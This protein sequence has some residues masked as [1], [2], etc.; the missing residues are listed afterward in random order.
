MLTLTRI[1]NLGIRIQGHNQTNAVVTEKRGGG[2]CLD[3]V[4]HYPF[5]SMVSLPVLGADR[6]FATQKESIVM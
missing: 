4:A 3:G 6:Q 2:H 1:R 5:H